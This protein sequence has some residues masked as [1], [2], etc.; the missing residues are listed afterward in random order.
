[1]GW[2]DT[3]RW[4]G[5]IIVARRTSVVWIL[6]CSLALSFLMSDMLEVLVGSRSLLGFVWVWK[7]TDVVVGVRAGGLF[8]NP[9]DNRGSIWVFEF[10]Y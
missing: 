10:G 3:W 7:D 6:F 4:A 8:L 1:M 2:Q 5:V 9:S